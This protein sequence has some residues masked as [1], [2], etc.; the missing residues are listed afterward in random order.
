MRPP[1]PEHQ[2]LTY[3][4]QLQDGMDTRAPGAAVT[5]GLCGHWDHEGPCRWPH[6]STITHEGEQLYTLRVE[7]RVSAQELN[8]VRARILDELAKGELIGPDGVLCTWTL[9]N[10]PPS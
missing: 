8:E 3:R 2:A 10:A 7:V 9:L 1:S 4:L 6:L 5:V